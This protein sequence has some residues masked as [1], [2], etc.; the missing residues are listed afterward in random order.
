MSKLQRW[1]IQGIAY[2]TLTSYLENRRQIVYNAGAS[3]SSRD[4]L[5]EVPQGSVLGPLLFL[6][7]VNDPWLEFQ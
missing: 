2:Q 1:D 5:H 6:I 7:L 3:P 4:F